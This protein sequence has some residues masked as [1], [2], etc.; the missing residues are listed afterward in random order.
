MKIQY[1][2]SILFS[3]YVLN[4]QSKQFFLAF[5]GPEKYFNFARLVK[6]KS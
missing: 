6:P 2:K 1:P 5:I 3:H 4:I